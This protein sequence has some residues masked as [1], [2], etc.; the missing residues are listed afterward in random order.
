MILDKEL[1]VS[2]DQA[3]TATAV[4]TNVIDLQGAGLG[5]MSL[6]EPLNLMAQ[7]SNADFAG[8][9]SIAVAVQTSADAAFSTPVIAYTT[10]AIALADL[11]A[12]YQFGL[13]KLPIGG[14]R[15]LRFN[16]VVVGTMSAGNITG[17]IVPE[18]QAGQ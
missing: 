4:S 7:V 1:L 5:D 13:G 18:L 11:V 6:G 10:A 15:Y 16:Y 8:G 12:G 9:T 14:L 3:V 17:G 2:N